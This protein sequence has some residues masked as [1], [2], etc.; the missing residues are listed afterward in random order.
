L[1]NF[2]LAGAALS[3]VGVAGFPASCWMFEQVMRKKLLKPKQYA[4][5]ISL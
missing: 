3:D 4:S 2:T 5:G 1:E